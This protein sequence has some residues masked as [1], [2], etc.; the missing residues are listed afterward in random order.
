MSGVIPFRAG[1]GD[2][3]QAADPAAPRRCLVHRP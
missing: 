1:F 2:N 3:A